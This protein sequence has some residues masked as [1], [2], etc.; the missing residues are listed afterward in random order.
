MALVKTL[1]CTGR[2]RA[3]SAGLVF[4]GELRVPRRWG[5]AGICIDGRRGL[6]N[7]SRA[8]GELSGSAGWLRGSA[9]L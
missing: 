7:G 8:G 5:V 2:E 1:G 6:V 4:E 3:G 9:N